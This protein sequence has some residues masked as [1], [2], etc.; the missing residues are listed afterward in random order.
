MTRRDLHEIRWFP[1]R[2][3]PS[4]AG[5]ASS[6]VQLLVCYHRRGSG[7]RLQ[8]EGYVCPVAAPTDCGYFTLAFFLPEVCK[9]EEAS[10]KVSPWRPGYGTRWCSLGVGTV[11][12]HAMNGASSGSL[13]DLAWTETYYE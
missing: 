12:A 11:E 9:I 5:K 6:T 1:R 13:Q 4:W 2:Q 3:L 7:I 8:R 10:R